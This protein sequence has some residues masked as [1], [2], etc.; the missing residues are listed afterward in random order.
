LDKNKVAIVTG[1]NGG[2]GYHAARQL[3]RA[4]MSVVLA[5]RDEARGNAALQKLRAENPDASIELSILDLSS[6]KSVAE[7][8]KSFSSKWDKL[9]LLVNNAAV[10]AIPNRMTS[11]DGYELQF[12]TNHLGHFALTGQL[13]PLLKQSSAPRVV[14]VS[15]IAHR[16]GK[17]NFADLQSEQSY[18]GWAAYGTTKLANLLFAFELARR[19]K[20]AGINLA[21]LAC[22]PGISR[23]NILSSGPQMGKKVLRTYV[24]EFFTSQFAQTD[25]E[26]ARP[27]VHACIST[28]A[29]S[30]DYYGPNGL[31]EIRGA[32]GK[33]KATPM[34]RD[35][36]AAKQLWEVS[37]SLTSTRFSV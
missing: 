27:I 34:A 16:Y 29:A 4:G 13:M 19:T 21:S 2:I 7:F 20:T 5:C 12:A 17:L 37:E 33:A 18:E 11:V 35:E 1:A 6:L 36:A 22:H 31:L 30:G 24:S 9:D 3:S 28:E 14:T 23:T 26:G 25:A 8:S 10:M 32:P 15:S